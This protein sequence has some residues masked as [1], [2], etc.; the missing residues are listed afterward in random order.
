MEENGNRTH[1]ETQMLM[2]DNLTHLVCMWMTANSCKLDI[3][4]VQLGAKINSNSDSQRRET[5]YGLY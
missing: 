3:S 1:H 2:K 4:Q 5:D